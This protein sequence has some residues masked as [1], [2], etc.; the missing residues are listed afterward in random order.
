MTNVIPISSARPSPVQLSR[1]AE[2]QARALLVSA[3]I[4]MNSRTITAAFRPSARTNF[5]AVNR[6]IYHSILDLTHL[7]ARTLEA[8]QLLRSKLRI[9]F[10]ELLDRHRKG[11]GH[12]SS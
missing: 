10:Y 1:Y 7:R 4:P 9:V 6:W 11:N 12:G 2:T 5:D 8:D 3:G